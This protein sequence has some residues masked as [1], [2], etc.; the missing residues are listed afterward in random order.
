MIINPHRRTEHGAGRRGG[1]WRASARPAAAGSRTLKRIAAATA[2]A[3]LSL[4]A[5]AGAAQA[6]VTAPRPAH[7]AL[8]AGVHVATVNLHRRYLADL[9]HVKVGKISGILRPR[10]W[11]APGA[12]KAKTATCTE[13]DCNVS[14]GGGPVQHNPAVFLV[15]WGPNW[16]P[17][18]TG[19]E[20]P[21]ALE[22]INLYEGLGVTP[23]DT[24]SPITAQYS[25]GSGFP[26]FTGGSLAGLV[27]DDTTPPTGATV[28]QLGAEAEAYASYFGFD[29][30]INTDSQI[31]VATQSLTCPEGFAAPLCGTPQGSPY[32]AWHAY[33]SDSS[34]TDIPF[35]N[36]PYMLDAGT[37][38]GANWVN[39]G[40]AGM[41]DGLTMAEGHE[42]AESI[43]DPIGQTGWIDK[44]DTSGGEIGDKCDWALGVKG[45]NVTLPTGTF[46][47]QP[48][49]SNAAGGCV[50]AATGED[51]VS[52]TS[53]GTQNTGVNGTVSLQLTGTSSGGHPLQWTAS[54]LPP[55]LSIS[56]SGLIT[57][58]ATTAKTY[59]PTLYANDDTGAASVAKVT[60]NVVTGDTVTVTNPGNQTSYAQA[61]VSV[62]LSGSSSDGFTPLSWGGTFPAGLYIPYP[63][64]SGV[65]TGAP[66]NPGTWPV[67]I[68]A[69]DT[70]GITGSTSFS[71]T[72]KPDVGKQLKESSAKKCLNDKNSVTTVGNAVNIYYCKPAGSIVGLGAQD[73][74]YSTTTGQLKVFG[75]CLADPKNGGTGTKLATAKCT[76]ATSEHWTYKTNGEYVLKL[77]SLC[78]TDPNAA[79]KNGIRVTITA[80]HD[81]T[82]QKWTKP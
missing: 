28:D 45:A 75:L 24:W 18:A 12:A 15:L 20:W 5:G 38:C 32:C 68:T 41:Y 44:S 67:T 61:A 10:G 17:G 8:P 31:V 29:S 14:Y 25:D 81:T 70:A 21:T 30:A 62:P 35:T 79:T 46:A 48:L 36:L 2:T 1:R 59:T 49:W 3:V 64:T 4:M 11:H 66:Y 77:N 43:T 69:T 52:I 27:I 37:F 53:P 13:P 7:L 9:K 71:W 82:A 72:V 26:A 16:E 60:W 34:F 23:L 33:F 73:W 22:M 63:Y 56:P 50:M 78:L 42:Y 55:G 40:N 6:Q 65:L 57:G 74:S 76:S 58:T 47:M 80:C 51:T 19:T 54:G 39:P